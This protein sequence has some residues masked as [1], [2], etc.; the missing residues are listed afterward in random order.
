MKY[1]TSMQTLLH[2]VQRALPCTLLAGHVH[3]TFCL[4]QTCCPSNLTQDVRR[5]NMMAASIF[6]RLSML[7]STSLH[8]GLTP[9]DV[10][11]NNKQVAIVRRLEHGAAFAGWLS[12][13]VTKYVS[14]QD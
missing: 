12:Q 8:A 14:M 1:T 11:I 2:D 3:V 4:P 7:V 13:K 6:S 10:A 9:V 5:P